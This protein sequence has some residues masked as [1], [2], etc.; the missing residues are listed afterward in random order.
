VND[1]L[2]YQEVPQCLIKNLKILIKYELETRYLTGSIDLQGVIGESLW[3]K[4]SEIM[5][6]KLHIFKISS[7][8]QGSVKTK[9][10][11]SSPPNIKG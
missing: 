4:K 2:N 9:I 6:H 10:S 8:V 7:M 1:K 3:V 5:F 11:Y